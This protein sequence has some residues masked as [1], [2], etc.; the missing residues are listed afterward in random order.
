MTQQLRGYEH[1]LPIA[2]L[3]A[4][5]AT[6]RKF[7]PQ[8]DA[9]GLTMQQWR[10]IRA[11]A[12]NESLVANELAERCVILPSSITRILSSLIAKGYIRTV[13]DPDARRKAVSL[14]PK[15]MMIYHQMAMK[16]E[17]IYRVLEE[18]FSRP[19]MEQLLQL[20]AQLRAAADSIDPDMLPQVDHDFIARVDGTSAG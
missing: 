8:V 15:G 2:L 18:R 3:R 16:S 6:M 1:A 4:R 9:L 14:T 17:A 12:E 11:L 7:K 13:A 19:N 20:L 5:E 10:V